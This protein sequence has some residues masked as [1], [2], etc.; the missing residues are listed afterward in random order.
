V[1]SNKKKYQQVS[2]TRILGLNQSSQ[3]I[4][5]RNRYNTYHIS[6]MGIIV[7]GVMRMISGFDTLQEAFQLFYINVKVF[8]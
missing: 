4:Q 8:D 3:S 7:I 1:K 5:V 2:D 6:S